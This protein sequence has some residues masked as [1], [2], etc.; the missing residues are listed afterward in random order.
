[1]ARERDLLICAVQFLTRLPTPRLAGFQPDWVSRAARYF[2]LVGQLIGLICAV[3]FWAASQ[4]RQGVIPALL[5]IAA[6]VLVTG[7]FHEDGLADAADG[8]GGGGDPTRR[9]EIMK[10]SRIGVYGALALGLALSLKV[11][12]LAVLPPA[13]GAL[14][15]FVYHGCARG[16]AVLAMTSLP[17]VGD[18]DAAKWKPA[19]I[20]VTR[21]EAA[22][23]LALA[24]WPLLIA[25]P[26]FVLGVLG[27]AALALMLAWIARRLIGGC[28]GDVLGAIEQVFEV[29]F[30]LAVSA[31][32]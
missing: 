5:A 14:A 31:A 7:A 8:L 21:G 12:A 25:P 20:G 9:L 4:V 30:L 27:G 16:A 32:L 23:A 6:G 29:G 19:P 13:S 22:L 15:L 3:V 11:A 17:Y 2:P 24:A 18:R 26:A 10:D 1:M 28:T